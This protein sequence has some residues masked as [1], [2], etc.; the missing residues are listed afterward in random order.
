M[1]REEEQDLLKV[2]FRAKQDSK[3][4]DRFN[5]EPSRSTITGNVPSHREHKY[6]TKDMK[7][8]RPWKRWCFMAVCCLICIVIMILLTLW[9]QKL[10][11]PDEDEDWNDDAVNATDDDLVGVA[12]A[13][14]GTA[15]TLSQTMDYIEDVCSEQRIGQDDRA[16]CEAACEPAKDCCDPFTNG[17]NSTCFEKEGM[18][19]FSYAK[20]HSLDGFL[21]PAHNNLDRIC[22][23][24]SLEINREECVNACAS[25]SCC[26]T[27][28]NS[29]VASNF[30]ACMDYA[31]CQNLLEDSI[32]VAPTDL[33]E[34]CGKQSPTCKRDCREALACS[35]PN[36]DTYRNNFLS[37]LSY[38]ACSGNS[39]TEV[40]VA[41]IY[42]RVKPA[43]TMLERLCSVEGFAEFGS[44]DRCLEAC[45]A[46]RCCWNIETDGC[47]G[48]D[49][50]GC[51][52][53]QKCFILNK[54]E[55]SDYTFPPATPQPQEEG[56][57][58]NVTK[59]SE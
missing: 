22:S 41:P 52:E 37:C 32:D 33:D 34:R 48:D 31:A 15:V 39:D 10:F 51:L 13:L 17:G 18:G 9:L 16:A 26:F 14:T 8:D 5:D 30:Q 36:S 28:E 59:R 55:Y 56:S 24:A 20:C 19:C 38:A 43:P 7:P 54:P 4:P 21:D 50:L 25:V 23:K 3:M 12:G 58:G 53:Y 45:S 47:F 57:I 35:D 1:H 49:P 29:C 2:S 27:P 44:T 40:K 6:S 11:D 46:A 42:S